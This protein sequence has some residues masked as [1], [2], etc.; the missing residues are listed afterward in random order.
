MYTKNWLVVKDDTKRTFEVCGKETNIDPFM[1]KIHAMHKAGMNVTGTTPPVTNKNA[2]K[3]QIL[4]TG[5]KIEEGLYNRLLQQLADI[6][7]A[8]V[9][10]ED[11]DL[12]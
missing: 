9:N 1:N 3:A 2:N 11:F 5:Y 6:T 12:D 4:I 7:R 8:S 10:E